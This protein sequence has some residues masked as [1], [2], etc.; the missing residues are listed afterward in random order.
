MFVIAI[1][2][3]IAVFSLQKRGSTLQNIISITEEKPMPIA[4]DRIPSKQEN[5][6]QNG[7]SSNDEK[8]DSQ[9]DSG[10]S[11][12]GPSFQKT[13]TMREMLAGIPGISM[14]VKC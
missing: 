12:I 7:P 13:Q 14:K 4:I 5:G 3:I 9:S 6:L 2:P 8:S 1:N 11:S 10:K